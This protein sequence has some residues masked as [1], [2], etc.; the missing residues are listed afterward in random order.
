M[1]DIGSI[2]SEKYRSSIQILNDYA[3]ILKDGH[4]G[5]VDITCM[6]YEIALIGKQI[7]REGG[8]R[9][10]E[11]VYQCLHDVSRDILTTWATIR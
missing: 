7:L 3:I 1:H 4:N 2:V 10:L 8:E 9:E 5:S 11:A 6:K